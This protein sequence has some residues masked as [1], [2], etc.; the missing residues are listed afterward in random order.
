MGDSEI[1][2]ALDKLCQDAELFRISIRFMG[3]QFNLRPECGESSRFS[4]EL[5]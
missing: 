5:R 4:Q 2:P 3:Y 1:R